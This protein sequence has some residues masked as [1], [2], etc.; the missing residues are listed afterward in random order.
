LTGVSAVLLVVLVACVFSKGTEP[1]PT[2][3]SPTGTI[4]KDL[5]PSEVVSPTPGP[6]SSAR[7]ISLARGHIKHI[8]FLIKENR[9]FD[10]MF[11]RFPGAD[12]ATQGTMCDGSTVQLG[13]AVD[14]EPDFGHSFTDGIADINGGAMDCFDPGAY[15]TYQKADIPNYYAYAKRFVLADHFFSSVYGPTGIEHLWTFAS[16]SDRLVDHERPGQIGSARREFCD[17]P[18][19][20]A[21]SFP[22]MSRAD[23]ENIYR[24]EDEGPAGI[25]RLRAS[26]VSRWPCVNVKVLPDELA[27]AGISWKEYRSDA[28]WIQPLRMVRHI[29]FSSMYRNVVP[30]DRFL[31]DLHAGTLPSVSWLNPPFALSDHP[32]YSICEGENWTVSVLNQIM[33]SPY[34]RSTAIVMTWDDFGGFY[35]HVP[36]PHLDLYG[37]GARVPALVISPWAKRSFVDHDTLEF[38]SVLRFIETVFHLP[39]LTSRDANA[40][41]MLG[42]FDF[43]Q[44]PQP[45]LILHTRSCP[46]KQTAP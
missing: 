25:D 14:R 4:P 9:T 32:P 46:A 23:Q 29:R 43:T 16:Q 7:Q 13:R 41:D 8:V 38:A 20:T 36:P 12:G 5:E 21:F 6:G 31:Q 30:S 19:E 1:A 10:N 22:H 24:I 28:Q 17:D 2:T 37:L 33:Q 39:P 26:F 40:N 44:K 18:L 34:W 11:G 35:D 15:V 45:G 42:A 27:A 3:P